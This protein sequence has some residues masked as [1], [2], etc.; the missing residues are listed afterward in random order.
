MANQLDFSRGQI[1]GARKAGA[2]E[3]KMVNYLV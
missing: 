1:I 3:T 2:S